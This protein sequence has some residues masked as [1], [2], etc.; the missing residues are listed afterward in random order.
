MLTYSH[1]Q[2]HFRFLA[3]PLELRLEIY[4]LASDQFCKLRQVNKQ[5]EQE[6]IEAFCSRNVL[7]I[8][9]QHDGLIVHSLGL[10]YKQPECLDDTE[11]TILL[12]Q[13]LA[14]MNKIEIVPVGAWKQRH[15]WFQNENRSKE[16]NERQYRS[17]GFFRITDNLR[18]LVRLLNGSGKA[19][20]LKIEVDYGQSPHIA[21]GDYEADL[22]EAQNGRIWDTKRLLLG[23]KQVRNA[24]KVIWGPL[25]YNEPYRSTWR[26][27]LGRPERGASSDL[28]D[29]YKEKMEKFILTDRER[30]PDSEDMD[31]F[32][33]FAELVALVEGHMEFHV[34]WMYH[35]TSMRANRW[36]GE[37]DKYN[38]HQ[39]AV[40]RDCADVF[41]SYPDPAI[42]AR[43][44]RVDRNIGN[45]DPVSRTWATRSWCRI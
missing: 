22:V 33:F 20:E 8:R 42:R 6:A 40:L 15:G 14:R 23:L 25:I 37:V 2:G 24:E 39:E 29:D 9:V 13:L 31:E 11:P 19:Y 36:H 38:L 45:I 17:R 10:R 32:A 30:D 44:R 41:K 4:D 43:F 5:I 18:Y 26:D 7:H 16:T 3:L 27:K 35:F 12:Q 21:V 1:I 34:R 28:L